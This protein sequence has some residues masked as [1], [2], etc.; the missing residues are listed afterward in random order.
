MDDKLTLIVQLTRLSI[1]VRVEPAL[2]NIFEIWRLVEELIQGTEMLESF[3]FQTD[4]ICV[5]LICFSVGLLC[6]VP[7]KLHFYYYNQ[8]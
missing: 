5:V 8:T 4:K 1:L 3:Y 7:K 2:N 6:T